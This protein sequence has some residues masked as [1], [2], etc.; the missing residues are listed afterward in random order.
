[1]VFRTV[2]HVNFIYLYSTKQF[3]ISSTSSISIRKT[4]AMAILL[5]IDKID[6][7]KTKA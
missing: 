6:K 1:M 7:F 3:P 5:R 4:T 2:N